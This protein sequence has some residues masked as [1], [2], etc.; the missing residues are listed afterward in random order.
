MGGGALTPFGV[1]L[2]FKIA[3]D[4]R[5]GE[6]TADMIG[7]VKGLVWLKFQGWGELHRDLA[8][9]STSQETRAAIER[10]GDLFRIPIA[11]RRAVD[12]RGAQVWGGADLR[13]GH[14]DPLQVGVAQILARENVDER[15]A[16][17]F[18][19]SQLALSGAFVGSET[20]G[21]AQ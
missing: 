18:A 19:R 20:S 12:G 16:H 7:F 9:Q 10:R 1:I 17:K 4:L 3:R 15:M 6:E 21:H 11:K 2:T 5:L 14:R 13:N 8:P